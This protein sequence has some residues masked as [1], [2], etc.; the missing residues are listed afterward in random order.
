VKRDADHR[1]DDDDDDDDDGGGGDH[2]VTDQRNMTSVL[3]RIF[4]ITHTHLVR[5]HMQSE[6]PVFSH[7]KTKSPN[8]KILLSSILCSFK[9]SIITV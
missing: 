7:G 8:K 1:H 5:L 2:V 4:Y 3:M 6:A 9:F